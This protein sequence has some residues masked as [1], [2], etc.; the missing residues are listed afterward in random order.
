[1]A[2]REPRRVLIF[3][4]TIPVP[5]PLPGPAVFRVTESADDAQ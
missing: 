5:V 2:W 4:A 1:M 3:V